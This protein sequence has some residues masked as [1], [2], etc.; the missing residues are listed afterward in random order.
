[1]LALDM[2]V[3][4]DPTVVPLI[5]HHCNDGRNLAADGDVCLIT[6]SAGAGKSW[7]IVLVSLMTNVSA[8]LG[9]VN[10]GYLGYL[11]YSATR[12]AASPD[13]NT[14]SLIRPAKAWASVVA[15]VRCN[16]VLVAS[17]LDKNADPLAVDIDEVLSSH[18]VEGAKDPLPQSPFGEVD[19]QVR[20]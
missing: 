3:K 20:V 18:F 13:A 12:A 7:W 6:G 10:L 16:I 14:F 9:K 17:L 11:G 2:L 1:M 15:R 19:T 5:G 8:R 4:L